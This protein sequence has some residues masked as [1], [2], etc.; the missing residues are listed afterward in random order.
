MGESLHGSAG[1]WPGPRF[2]PLQ[3]GYGISAGR[4]RTAGSGGIP[5][6]RGRRPALHHHAAGHG[7][8][9]RSVISASLGPGPGGGGSSEGSRLPKESKNSCEVP[10]VWCGL[11]EGSRFLLFFA[12]LVGTCNAQPLR[13]F[14][15][16][17]ISAKGY[18]T[19]SSLL[20]KI[21]AGRAV[22]E[23]DNLIRYAARAS[24]GSVHSLPLMINEPES[25]RGKETPTTGGAKCRLAYR[26]GLQM[27]A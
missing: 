26:G 20:Q 24:S 11:G 15:P 16:K 14:G 17:H 10:S 21:R 5:R 13:C 9:A 27:P 3:S 12:P 6:A 18:P 7:D 4:G 1:G 22:E 8:A 19:G 2:Y 23:P 25:L